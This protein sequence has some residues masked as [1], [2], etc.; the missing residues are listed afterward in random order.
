MDTVQ[1]IV[2]LS[3]ANKFFLY[4]GI[5]LV[6]NLESGRNEFCVGIARLYIRLKGLQNYCCIFP[7]QICHNNPKRNDEKSS[8]RCGCV[9]I[10]MCTARLLGYLQ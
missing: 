3:S 2:L 1:S 9:I 7:I 8:D 5:V 6:R 4:I 10:C